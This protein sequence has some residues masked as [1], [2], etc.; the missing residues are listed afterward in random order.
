M[1]YL[2]QSAYIIILNPL[3][4]LTGKIGDQTRNTILFVLSLILFAYF[5]CVRSFLL[6]PIVGIVLPS[7]CSR[8]IFGIVL[9]ILLSVFSINQRLQHIE[10]NRIIIIPQLLMGLGI[11]ITGF[12]HP[13]GDGYLTFGFMLLFVFPCL[14]F[15]WNNRR[16]YDWLFSILIYAM[17]VANLCMLLLHFYF[18]AKGELK[19]EY[20]R[21][22]GL[23]HNSNC[24]SMAGLELVLGSLYMLVTRRLNW[25]SFVLFTSAAGAGLGMILLGQMRLAIIILF[26]CLLA[27]AIFFAR[28]CEK[29]KGTM[30][31]LFIG[32][33]ILFQLLLVTLLLV[34]INNTAVLNHAEYAANTQTE[35]EATEP[36][37]ENQDEIV[38]RFDV[39]GQDANSFSSGRVIRW[40]LYGQALNLLGNDFDQYDLT[41]MTGGQAY[42]YAHN[43]FFEI[44]YRCGIP[45]GLLSVFMILVTGIIGL[46][47]LFCNKRRTLYLLFPIFSVVAYA[48]EALLDC[49]ALPF[50]QAEALL[51]YFAMIVFID[52]QVNK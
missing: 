17:V 44:G 31:R 33:M 22:A 43:I 3:Y 27:T 42:P 48:V 32:L 41:E 19:M 14:Y 13:I 11:V 39:Q 38:E 23:M 12:L 49:A 47:Y 46:K 34:P 25:P 16:D 50:F 37:D 35:Q 29:P 9:L 36:I 24:F 28:Y 6:N 5:A 21:C 52:A 2:L 40:K 1:S 8:H 15:V 18:A 30:S 7:F 51:Y 45:V 4:R 20:A 10:W 26:F